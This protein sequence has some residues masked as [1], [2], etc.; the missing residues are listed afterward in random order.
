MDTTGLLLAT[1][2]GM[3]GHK[4][5]HPSHHVEKTYVAH[6]SGKMGENEARRLREGV[7]I[8]DVASERTI[9]TAPVKVRILR[10]GKRAS[11]VQLVIHEGR[12]RQVRR[13]CKA[14]GHPVLQLE[15]IQIGSL[16]LGDMPLGAWRMLTDGELADLRRAIDIGC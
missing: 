9:T 16:S 2:D 7:R 13:M 3:L 15:R 4:L 14:V 10:Q 11:V 5:S 12:N 8:Y 6:V 1:S